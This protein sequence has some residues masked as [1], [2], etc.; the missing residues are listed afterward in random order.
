M[1]GQ[2]TRAGHWEAGDGTGRMK[3]G[4][5]IWVVE[6]RRVGARGLQTGIARFHNGGRV[7]SRSL[8]PESSNLGR[9]DHSLLT[10][11]ATMGRGLET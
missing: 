9:E 8:K 7:I 11:T 5:G 4:T 1:A 6:L 2:G 3:L 10:S